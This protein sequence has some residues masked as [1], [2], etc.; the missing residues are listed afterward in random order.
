MKT[1]T[2]A[3]TTATATTT[4]TW[5]HIWC[6]QGENKGT[7]Y[8]EEFLRSKVQI[9]LSSRNSNNSNSINNNNSCSLFSLI[10]FLVNKK[11]RKL[12]KV[13]FQC[14]LQVERTLQFFFRDKMF[15]KIWSL[16]LLSLVVSLDMAEAKK[17]IGHLQTKTHAVKGTV[18]ILSRDQI[19]TWATALAT[20]CIC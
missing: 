3:T 17:K 11:F 9:F 12:K 8:F 20:A 7:D 6:E 18:Y 10:L 19:L 1:T 2:R 4:M 13:L 15:C 16:F 5:R 14:E